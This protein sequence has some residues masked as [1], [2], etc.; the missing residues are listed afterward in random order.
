MFKGARARERVFVGLMWLV[1]VVLAGF[2]IG[3]GSL[4]IGDLPRVEAPVAIEQFV[5][6]ARTAAIKRDQTA[7][8]AASVGLS[9]SKSLSMSS[10]SGASSCLFGIRLNS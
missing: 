1:S 4:V 9:R 8:A 3:L 7:L 5:D 10:C 2:L 6:P